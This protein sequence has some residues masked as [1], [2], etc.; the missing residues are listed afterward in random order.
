MLLK[1]Y[2]NLY[3]S[4]NLTP[5]PVR[6]N[7]K[8]PKYKEWVEREFL[9]KDFGENDNIGVKSG[10]GWLLI[11]VDIADFEKAKRVILKIK[12]ELG[13]GKEDYA[14]QRTASGKWH[15]LFRVDEDAISDLEIKNRL[16]IPTPESEYKDSVRGRETTNTIDL[17][18]ESNRQFVVEPSTINGRQ[19][20]W[21]R[22]PSIDQLKLGRS[23]IVKLMLLF[24]R[25]TEEFN[26][27]YMLPDNKNI[28]TK[29]SANNKKEH[30][31]GSNEINDCIKKIIDRIK[32]LDIFDIVERL[33][34]Q[35]E[36]KYIYKGYRLYYCPF[37]AENTPSFAVR[38]DG[39]IT[40]FHDG[41]GFDIIKL[42]EE[43]KGL[44]FIDAIKW[45]ATEFNI[46][47]SCLQQKE[48]KNKVAQKLGIFI[49]KKVIKH[50]T[51]PIDALI[52]V[53]EINIK[54]GNIK[55]LYDGTST[56][57][58]R[59]GLWLNLD[60]TEA[61][62][63]ILKIAKITINKTPGED[64][65]KR[66]KDAIMVIAHDLGIKPTPP[67]RVTWDGEDL[68]YNAG[69]HV[70]RITKNGYKIED[71][72][73]YFQYIEFGINQ[74][75]PKDS[76][77]KSIEKIIFNLCPPLPQQEKVIW[78]VRLISLYIPEIQK[79]AMIFRGD[80]GSGKTTLSKIT[81][82]LFDPTKQVALTRIDTRDLSIFFNYNDFGILDNITYLTEEISN[83]LCSVVTGGTITERK[84]YTNME[85]VI[86]ELNATFDLTTIGLRGAKEDL[87][88]R[89][90]LLD[91]RKIKK[92]ETKD[93]TKINKILN[94]FKPHILHYIYTILSK[95]LTIPKPNKK[96]LH[97]FSGWYYWGYRIA[98]AMDKLNDYELVLTMQ[99]D[100]S[101]YAVLDSYGSIAY[102]MWDTLINYKSTLI[103]KSQLDI[104]DQNK[105]TYKFTTKE[106]SDILANKYPE[107]DPNEFKPRRVGRLIAVLKPLL[108]E[109][110]IELE[111]SHSREGTVWN[112]RDI[113]LE[114]KKT[115]K[116][117]EQDF[118]EYIYDNI[119]TLTDEEID[120]LVGSGSEDKDD[121][122]DIDG[123]NADVYVNSNE[124][125]TIIDSIEDYKEYDGEDDDIPWARVK[126]D[127]SFNIEELDD[128]VD[129]DEVE[130]EEVPVEKLKQI[131]E[132]EYKNGNVNENIN[133]KTDNDVEADGEVEDVVVY[134]E[135]YG[136]KVDNDKKDDKSDIDI[137]DNSVRSDSNNN[138]DDVCDD[139]GD[140]DGIEF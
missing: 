37:H 34:L 1:K 58:L 84:L 111:K 85:M 98:Q 23:E 27:K 43:L 48:N 95:A 128:G 116:T 76:N 26:K 62:L 102:A 55:V 67:K 138:S 94:K 136:G 99:Q 108:L 35:T 72:N 30:S 2:Y 31:D 11:D 129:V 125:V 100:K 124:E 113:E 65:L 75:R 117:E 118:M 41:R 25:W 107:I 56:F 109:R 73:E 4:L 132:E 49:P 93:Y 81:K 53:I 121:K 140:D 9:L 61:K 63:Y 89:A 46:D 6:V 103:N 106:I 134:I 133:N 92:N 77:L 17:L 45:I 42:T 28:S 36:K 18:V 80:P 38:E 90:L 20:K 69:D 88:D 59:D 78:L 74:P 115:E 51:N 114:K 52:R 21:I 50:I 96:P 70:I 32:K 14:L 82:S 137:N 44:S 131:E 12:K 40:D 91:F 13:I 110:G 120:K 127:D 97:R 29:E 104:S 135:N 105:N 64:S 60:S 126:P 83:L 130:V 8:I 71:H 15:L 139:V 87:V 66:V 122:D 68:L 79:P 101:L 24:D 47:I 5:I 112:I 54:K 39:A 7:S 57:I 33:G 3:T 19:Y 86:W 16:H 119:E 22:R 10:N 123:D